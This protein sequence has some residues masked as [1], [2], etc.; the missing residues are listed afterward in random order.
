MIGVKL[1]KTVY[2]LLKWYF[3]HESKLPSFARKI[4][5]KKINASKVIKK[6]QLNC[7]FIF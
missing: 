5:K 3:S 7:H 6:I 4:K 1:K 2:L